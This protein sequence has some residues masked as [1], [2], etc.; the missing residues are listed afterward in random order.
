MSRKTWTSD[1][2]NWDELRSILCSAAYSFIQQHTNTPV[3]THRFFNPLLAYQ[4]KSERN[5]AMQL[6]VIIQQMDTQNANAPLQLIAL[7]N[8]L[9]DRPLLQKVKTIAD[10]EALM[11]HI[12]NL[13]IQGEYSA[14]YGKITNTLKSDIFRRYLFKKPKLS[15]LSM[16]SDKITH[17]KTEAI[18]NIFAEIIEKINTD[19]SEKAIFAAHYARYSRLIYENIDFPEAILFDPNA[20]G[21]KPPQN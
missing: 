7:C 10:T 16:S 13:L 6:W 2:K 21:Y 19:P 15:T 17:K 1:I 4:Q 5:K 9:F 11:N 3:N 20:L 14:S 12:A 8:A 18:K